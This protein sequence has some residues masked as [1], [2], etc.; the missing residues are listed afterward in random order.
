R[1]RQR[2]A[3]HDAGAERFVK[4]RRVGRSFRIADQAEGTRAGRKEPGRRPPDVDEHLVSLVTPSSFAAEQYRVLR[5]LVEQMHKDADLGVVAVTSPA[6]GDG[7]TTTAINLAGSLAQ[8]PDARVLLI[9]ADLRAGSVR[10]HLRLRDD[11]GP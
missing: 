10:E 2:A 6:A 4:P 9:D 8:A 5:H 11:T 7:K 3:C 1:Q